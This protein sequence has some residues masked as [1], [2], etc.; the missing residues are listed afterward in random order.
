MAFASFLLKN[1]AHPAVTPFSEVAQPFL[2]RGRAGGSQAQLPRRCDS[3]C[4]S[5]AGAGASLLHL[6][7]HG[8]FS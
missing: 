7:D 8:H 6:S 2:T 4:R 5:E 3:R 1:H